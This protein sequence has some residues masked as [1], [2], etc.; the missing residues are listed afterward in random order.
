[1]NY[2][3]TRQSFFLYSYDIDVKEKEKLDLFLKLLDKANLYEVIRPSLEKTNYQGRNRIQPCNML[4]TILYAFMIDNGHL[5]EIE[6]S[7]KISL[8]YMYL[9]NGEKASYVT[10]SNFI[11]DIILSNIFE[12][13]KRINQALISEIGFDISDI[14]ID[15]SKFEAN[16][17]KYKFV[18]KPT[19]KLKRLENEIKELLSQYS[20]KP[21]TID[22]ASLSESINKLNELSLKSNIGLKKTLRG[23]GRKLTQIQKDYFKLLEYVPKLLKYH[24]QIRICG[25]NRNSYY[26]S[27][28]DATAMCLK[29]DYY[30]GLGSNMHAAYN[31][32]FIVAKGFILGV[33]VSQ[34]RTDY[35]TLSPCLEQF[36]TFYGTYPKNVCADAG[37]GSYDNYKHIESK[38]IGNY[39]KYP[40]W[41]G[42]R[43]G[44]SPQ[45]FREEEEKILCLNNRVGEK[46]E[47]KNRHPQKKEA[48]I[49]RFTGCRK[50]K[51][52]AICKKRT[53]KK[54]E[55][56]RIAE[57]CPD[58]LKFIEIVRENLLSP[59]GIELRVNRS[60][61]AEG[62]FG[63][64]KQN[65][66]YNRFRRRGKNKVT[67]EIILMSIGI[68]IRKYLRFKATGELPKFWIAPDNLQSEG[69]P[70][71]KIPK[72]TNKKTKAV[73][74]LSKDSHKYQ[75]K[76][77]IKS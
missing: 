36:K 28:H 65:L 15:G 13:F 35:M 2:F 43:K 72:S 76:R 29:E 54:T 46:I 7:C 18:W 31:V 34:D 75:R 69:K 17:N 56:F 10:F 32:Q 68:N 42:E 52:K 1:M 23:K 55:P 39:I 49:Y 44:T 66:S 51:Y 24:E 21:Q 4:A 9:M 5:R 22:M 48:F 45:L 73:N 57:I 77:T 11:N 37:Y 63:N 26:K 6:R 70:K 3:T 58:Y 50:C 62:D 71:I 40:S 8:D 74:Q 12:I 59:K 33:Y 14:F 60:I 20:I 27:D 53:K 67:M 19:K 25:E 64:M 38:Y 47:M 41:Q 61:Q 30:S 16:S